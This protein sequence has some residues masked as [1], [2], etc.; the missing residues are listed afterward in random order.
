MKILSNNEMTNEVYAEGTEE[1]ATYSVQHVSNSYND[2]LYNGTLEECI[3]YIEK[4]EMMTNEY[5]AQIALINVQTD[6]CTD[7]THEII[8]EW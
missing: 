3:H 4:N 7:Y 6:G 5:D 1:Y 2:D 8:K